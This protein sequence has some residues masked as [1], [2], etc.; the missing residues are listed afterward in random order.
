MLLL[1]PSEGLF[2]SNL[3]RAFFWQPKAERNYSPAKNRVPALKHEKAGDLKNREKNLTSKPTCFL[4]LHF[5]WVWSGFAGIHI[6][7]MRESERWC[8]MWAQMIT[9][10]KWHGIKTAC[11]VKLWATLA[12]LLPALPVRQGLRHPTVLSASLCSHNHPHPFPVLILELFLLVK[13]FISQHLTSRMVLAGSLLINS[14][15]TFIFKG[16]YR[17]G[18]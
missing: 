9:L 12:V 17:G 6:F 10:V 15:V 1:T 7:S 5:Q 14:D 11:G 3:V 16:F 18:E 2:Q 8:K 13:Q 4:Q